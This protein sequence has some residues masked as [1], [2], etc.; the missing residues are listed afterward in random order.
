MTKTLA[1]LFGI[2][3]LLMGIAGTVNTRLV[4]TDGLFAADAAYS[5]ALMVIGAV[6]LFAALFKQDAARSI[7]FSVGALLAL[8]AL[9]SLLFTPG[10]GEVLGM[11]VNSVDHVLNLA[12]GLTIAGTAYF[13][14]SRVSSSLRDMRYLRPVRH[15]M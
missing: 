13:E 1:T 6:L 4:G 8:V 10:R 9:S 2:V 7:T 11:F 3:Y 15:A 14:R 5:I 12:I